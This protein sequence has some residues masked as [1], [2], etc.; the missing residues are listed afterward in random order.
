MIETSNYSNILVICAYTYN[1]GVEKF[2][3]CKQYR[4]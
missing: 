2:V 4:K 3:I 1:Y